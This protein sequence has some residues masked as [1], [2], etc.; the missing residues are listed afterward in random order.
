MSEG[1]GGIRL[2]VDVVLCGECRFYQMGGCLNKEVT[3]GPW[4]SRSDEDY[5][6]KGIRKEE[7]DE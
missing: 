2:T 3:G 7:Q 6:S 4:K 5:C 1:L